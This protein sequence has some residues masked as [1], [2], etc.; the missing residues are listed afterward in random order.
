[1]RARCPRTDVELAREGIVL[2]AGGA[3]IALQVAH[4]PVAAGVQRHSNFT[5]DPLGR[6]RRTLEYLSA[7][8][9][10]EAQPARATVTDWVTRAHELVKGVAD[11]APYSAAD[12]DT[13]LWVT[14]TLYWSAEQVR[15][16]IWGEQDPADAEQIYRSYAL[17]GTSLGMPAS[18]WPEDRAAFARYWEQHISRLEV[19]A[20][21][22]Q[23][24][25]DLFV[26]RS[27]PWWLRAVMPVARFLTAGL[28]PPPVRVQLGLDW[29][30]VDSMREDR[31]WRS[32][33]RVYPRLPGTVRH[34]PARIVVSRLLSR[35]R[36]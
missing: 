10:P 7:V 20:A 34:A 21:A 11:G 22:R 5:A 31:L 28:L 18:Y 32:L 27:A 29:D 35:Y 33:A 24:V 8:V 9:L 25:D 30:G 36:E 1:M 16:R 23:I 2:A 17:L 26:A 14:A 12:P 4:R 19:T 15:W 6:L 13:Q 3:A